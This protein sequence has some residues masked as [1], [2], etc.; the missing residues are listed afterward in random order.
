MDRGPND[1]PI[2]IA[3]AGIAG[4]TAALALSREGFRS[5]IVEREEALQDAGAG[6]QLGPNATRILH[7]LGL[8]EAVRAHAV[9]PEALH[10][11]D[12]PSGRMLNRVP[13]GDAIEG[14]HGAP[15]LVLHR[16][17]LQRVLLAAALSDTRLVLD[18][19]AE[20]VGLDI[21]SDRIA[22]GIK[23]GDAIEGSCLIGADGLWSR[24]RGHIFPGARPRYAGRTAWRALLPADVVPPGID[25]ADVT[26]WLGPNAHLVHYAVNGGQALNVV[27]IVDD[28]SRPEGWSTPGDPARL[29][30]RFGR[31]ADLPRSLLAQAPEWRIWPLCAL[32]GLPRWRDGRVALIG[33]AAHLV[34]PFVAQGGALA[35]EDAIAI[36]DALRRS[37]G[38]PAAAFAAF[39]QD[40]RPRVERMRRLSARM[41]VYY[42][43]TGPARLIRN[44]VLRG[45]SPDSLLG[46]L[47]WIYGR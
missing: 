25:M 46:S 8:L 9:R 5:R 17:D 34:M 42:H 3:G 24:V 47:D 40:R 18:F 14:R 6:I 44:A 19:G 43:L 1:L 20:I 13:L 37:A 39:E 45:R 30:G 27:A 35:V 23:S 41:G 36:T 10:M 7:D 2:L 26:V 4:L 33:D 31:W 29:L 22:V 38:D 28:L 16:A 32:P 11:R 15:Y 21:R 12:G